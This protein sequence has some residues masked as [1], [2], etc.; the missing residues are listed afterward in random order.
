MASDVGQSAMT[1]DIERA[2]RA[3]CDLNIPNSVCS[4]PACRASAN[5]AAH[6]RVVIAALSA[7]ADPS[8]A[9]VEAAGLAIWGTADLPP[10]LFTGD[11]QRAVLDEA[12]AALRAANLAVLGR[13][14]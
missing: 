5:C 12:R 7:L 11:A 13:T 1:P 3:S 4:Y 10:D 8:D 6:E 2:I 9:A 14:E